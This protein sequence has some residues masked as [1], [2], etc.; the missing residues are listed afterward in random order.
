MLR[1]VANP[2]VECYAR[3]FGCKS[4]ADA[5][6][7]LCARYFAAVDEWTARGEYLQAYGKDLTAAMAGMEKLPE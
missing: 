1:R 2:R 4:K 6:R 5:Y 7:E 3:S